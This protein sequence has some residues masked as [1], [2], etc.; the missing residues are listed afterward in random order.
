MTLVLGKT[1]GRRRREQWRMR[2]LDGVMT[3]QISLSKLGD[4]EGRGKPGML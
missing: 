4:R 3:Q 2:W 1:E